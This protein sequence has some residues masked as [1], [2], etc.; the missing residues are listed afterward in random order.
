[1]L[2]NVPVEDA[3]SG[4]HVRFFVCRNFGNITRDTET[5]ESLYIVII[6]MVADNTG[7][8]AKVL[9]VHPIG[10]NTILPPEEVIVDI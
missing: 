3:E 8:T 7:K 6:D 9:N 1:M 5:V 2:N 10:S 4:S